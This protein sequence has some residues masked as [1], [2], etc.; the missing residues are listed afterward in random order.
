MKTGK[1]KAEKRIWRIDLEVQFQRKGIVAEI[2]VN[3]EARGAGKEK[4]STSNILKIIKGDDKQ[5]LLLICIAQSAMHL[6]IRC[7]KNH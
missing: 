7:Y 2:Q 5:N 4:T 3:E 6:L 1:T